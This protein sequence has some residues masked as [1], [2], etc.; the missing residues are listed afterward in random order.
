LGDG[1]RKAD[2]DSDGTLAADEL[3]DYAAVTVPSLVR[4]LGLKGKTQNPICFP[5]QPPKF[6]VVRK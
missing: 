5:R 2:L 4:Q 6:P 1:F 3:F